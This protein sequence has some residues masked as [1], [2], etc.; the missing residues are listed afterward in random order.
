MATIIFE[1]KCHQVRPT[2]VAQ[3]QPRYIVN[4]KLAKNQSVELYSLTYYRS[5]RKCSKWR[6]NCMVYTYHFL[7]L[8]LLITGHVVHWFHGIHPTSQHFST[9]LW[10][11]KNNV[12]FISTIQLYISTISSIYPLKWMATSE[13]YKNI[14]AQFLC[15]IASLIRYTVRTLLLKI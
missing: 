12:L 15:Q 9:F 4:T 13:K 8:P 6:K 3:E 10:I 11:F 1:G 14:I 2:V 5:I 7:F